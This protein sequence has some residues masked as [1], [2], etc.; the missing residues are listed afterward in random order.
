M[1]S[2]YC[3]GG[4]ASKKRV[5]LIAQVHNIEV[6]WYIKPCIFRTKKV[7]KALRNKLVE[8]IIKK[9]NLRESPI[10]RDTLLITDAESGVKMRVPKLLLECSMR[11]SHNEQNIFTR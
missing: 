2:A 9:S 8:R 7:S 1:S 3:Q 5:H 10:A 11:Q 4:K 6:K